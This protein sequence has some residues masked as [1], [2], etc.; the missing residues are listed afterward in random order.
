MRGPIRPLMLITNEKKKLNS[1]IF[2]YSGFFLP[3]F[4]FTLITDVYCLGM[5]M[6][7]VNIGNLLLLLSGA[8]VG[9]SCLGPVWTFRLW[10]QLN[11]GRVQVF[12]ALDR[13]PR[14]LVYSCFVSIFFDTIR[15]KLVG[16]TLSQHEV[17]SLSHT[18]IRHRMLFFTLKQ[19][20]WQ[21]QSQPNLYLSWFKFGS[22]N[23]K[24]SLGLF[25]FDMGY[26][27][28]GYV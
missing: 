18:L 27:L 16:S 7:W 23:D 4:Q 17:T 14:C 8:V 6:G 25:R 22:T 5:A 28:I 15:A 20:N 26:M 19:E 2:Q 9:M 11:L 3:H 21:Y 12:G 1:N 10:L 13:P 24:P